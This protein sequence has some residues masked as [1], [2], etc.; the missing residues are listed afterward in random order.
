MS[1]AGS[2]A[3]QRMVIARPVKP[4]VWRVPAGTRWHVDLAQGGV[5]VDLGIPVVGHPVKSAGRSLPSRRCCAPSTPGRGM[6]ASMSI[7]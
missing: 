3:R 4:P 7:N 5:L 1:A 6:R 2:R